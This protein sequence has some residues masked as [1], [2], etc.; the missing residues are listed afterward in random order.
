L[1]VKKAGMPRITVVMLATQLPMPSQSSGPALVSGC[2]TWLQNAFSR[3][4]R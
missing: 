3:A 1:G 4:M 2:S